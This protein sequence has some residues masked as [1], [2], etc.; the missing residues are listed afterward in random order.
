MTVLLYTLAP[1]AT[2]L[3]GA[4]ATAYKPPGAQL[5]SILQHFAG[6]VVF[7]AAAVELLPDIVHADA[8]LPTMIGSAL[9]IV[10]M[11]ALQSAERRVQ[12]PMGL[13]AAA[14]VDVLIDGLVL[15]LSFLHGTKQGLLMTIALSVEI[16]FLGLA[17]ASSIEGQSRTRVIGTTM[18]VAAAL[19]A[20]AAISLALTGLS[21]ATLSGFYAFGLIALLYLVTEELLVEAHEVEDRPVMPAAFFIGFV[22]LIYLDEFLR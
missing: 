8:M 7:A 6:G 21:Q 3:I 22:L 18:G 13:V 10:A 17:V 19:P 2:A 14:S 20:G 9:G 1:L 12:G 11:L 15:G 4:V 16:L 5:R